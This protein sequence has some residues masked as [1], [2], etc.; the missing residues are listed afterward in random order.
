MAVSRRG[1]MKGAGAVAGLA[2][3]SGS[4]AAAL[5]FSTDVVEGFQPHLL[6]SV[7]EVW[8]W[9]V[10]MN[11][12]GAKFTGNA[13]HKSFVEFLASKFNHKEGTVDAAS[14]KPVGHWAADGRPWNT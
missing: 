4:N 7:D 6:P 1:F 2:L 14:L 10:W 11:N 12:L 9:Q 13:A 8:D 5:P 3:V